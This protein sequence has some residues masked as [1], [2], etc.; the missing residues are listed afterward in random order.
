M[1]KYW[2][3][4]DCGEGRACVIVNCDSKYSRSAEPFSCPYEN[5]KRKPNYIE[6]D[7]DDFLS[8]ADVE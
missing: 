1:V 3:C 8:I 5:S 7:K 4:N 6:I 2:K